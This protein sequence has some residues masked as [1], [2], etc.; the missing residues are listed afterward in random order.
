MKN[1]LA[2][3]S[4]PT[5][6]SIDGAFLDSQGRSRARSG[7]EK[8]MLALLEDGI[9][10]FFKYLRAA[11]DKGR[12]ISEEI[13]KWIFG[14]DSD[15]IFSFDNVCETLGINPS[16]LRAKLGQWKRSELNRGRRHRAGLRSVGRVRVLSPGRRGRE[17]KKD[18]K[19]KRSC[20]GNSHEESPC[21]TGVS[22][23]AMRE[24]K[25]PGGV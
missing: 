19:A 1:A 23:R 5:A 13:D 11:D 24:D 18:S 7:E 10:S 17:Q 20:R 3:I 4:H 6:L 15:W 21:S 12:Q 8:L 2:L 16:C 14:R 25:G 9:D 22:H